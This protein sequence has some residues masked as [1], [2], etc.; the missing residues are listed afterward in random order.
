MISQTW[1]R[2]PRYWLWLV[3]AI[4]LVWVWQA[5]SLSN[6]GPVL[7][8]LGPAQIVGLLVANGLVLIGLSG[9]WWLIL[10]SQGYTLPYFSLMGYRLA[11][12]GVSYFT[13][14]PQFGGEPLQIY[15]VKQ[16]HQV[17]ASV[18][19]SA[20]ALDKLLELLVN[21]TFLAWGMIVVL[22]QQ[23]FPQTARVSGLV[24]ALG[25]LVGPLVILIALRNEHKPLSVLLRLAD[26]LTFWQPAFT[27]SR[28][29]RKLS[30]TVTETESQAIRFCQ[31]QPNILSQALL[32]S[33]LSWGLLVGEYWLA[34]HFLG[35]SL[36][37]GQTLVALTAARLAIL[38]PLPGGLGALEA[39][40]VLA[41]QVLG[42][43]PAVGLSLSLLIRLRDV[44]LAGFGL[45]WAGVKS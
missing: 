43:N 14:G 44:I 6:I 42:L 2:R 39:S 26:R 37:P 17:P 21:F 45:W 5:G 3:I 10:R 30:R 22:E 28:Y 11:A 16:R 33:I 23:L 20:V 12:F 7:T 19:I 38:F 41:M 29:Y 36:S 40:Q 34:L 25:L 8:R 18:A 15:L 35:Q 32:V 13:P 4:L 9:R 27:A 31:Q 1:L 24:F